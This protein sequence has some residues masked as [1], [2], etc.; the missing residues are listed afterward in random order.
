MN[1]LL[2]TAS[3]FTAAPTGTPTKMS[4][5]VNA[6]LQRKLLD[7]GKRVFCAKGSGHFD[8]WTENGS[9]LDRDPTHTGVLVQIETLR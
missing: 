3:D 4:A 8:A 9:D 1:D 7:Q 5:W 2:F 6:K